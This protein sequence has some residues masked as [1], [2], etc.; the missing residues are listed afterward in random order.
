MREDA[1]GIANDRPGAPEQDCIFLSHGD[2]VAEALFFV[3]MGDGRLIDVWEVDVT[4]LALEPGPDGWLLTRAPIEPSRLTLVE[5]W[6]TN[7]E[8]FDEGRRVFPSTE[9]TLR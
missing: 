6:Q 3:R 1:R 4:G 7:P 8:P 9:A 5:V 2:E